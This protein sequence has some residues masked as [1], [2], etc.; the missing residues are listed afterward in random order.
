MKKLAFAFGALI[1]GFMLTSC[2]D[3]VKE[4][5]MKDV[6][7]YFTGA[8]QVLATI[9]NAEDFVTF[10]ESMNDRDDL[11]EQLQ[12][13]YG[14]KHISDEDWEVIENYMGERA[15]AYNNAEADKCAEFLSPAIDRFEAILNEMY[16]QYEAGTPFDEETLDEFLD[17]YFGVT[18][19]SECEN[20]HTELS[21]RLDPLFEMEDEMSET[22]VARMDE[23]W[24]DEE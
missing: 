13:D 10:A 24:P 16:P 14:E 1:M 20:I 6:D 7:A 5:I 3:N 8:E 18:A 4:S 2:G 15:T 19:F 9:D 11:I 17:A 23:L 21:D 12:A 22:I